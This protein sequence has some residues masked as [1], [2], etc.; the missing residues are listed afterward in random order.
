MTLPLP[1]YQR[2]VRQL[3]DRSPRGMFMTGKGTP[4]REGW[5][6][7]LPNGL[8]FGTMVCDSV[9]ATMVVARRTGPAHEYRL[10]YLRPDGEFD[11][12]FES[13]EATGCP[14]VPVARGLAA[15]EAF[16]AQVPAARGTLEAL[17]LEILLED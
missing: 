2:Y 6:R 3:E 12:V 4:D 5:S 17:G 14:F 8:S 7:V 10:A 1:A 9:A 16:E 11:A 13:R 15:L